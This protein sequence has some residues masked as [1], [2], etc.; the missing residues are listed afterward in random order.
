MNWAFAKEDMMIP[1]NSGAFVS[2]VKSVFMY[3]LYFLTFNRM[4][5]SVQISDIFQCEIWIKFREATVSMKQNFHPDMSMVA[6]ADGSGP[7]QC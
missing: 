2:F 4:T 3:P 7:E 5:K 6:G 1:K